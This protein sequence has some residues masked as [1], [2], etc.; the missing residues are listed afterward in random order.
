CARTRGIHLQFFD[1]W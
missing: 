1:Y